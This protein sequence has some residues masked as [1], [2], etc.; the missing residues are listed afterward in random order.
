[1]KRAPCVASIDDARRASEEGRKERCL[2]E[3]EHI[4]EEKAKYLVPLL[5]KL[6]HVDVSDCPAFA[7]LCEWLAE[8]ELE[9]EP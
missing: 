4:A 2:I 9:R 5:R 3:V 8:R 6:E 7:D 1:M